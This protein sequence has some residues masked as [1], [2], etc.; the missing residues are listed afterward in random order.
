MSKR[1]G[2]WQR[3]RDR[4]QINIKHKIHI[5]MDTYNVSIYN[6]IQNEY[7]KYEMAN[8]IIAQYLIALHVLFECLLAFYR[9]INYPFFR[10]F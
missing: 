1:V 8:Y 9:L 10:K 3:K 7:N 5:F 2:E 6:I 4:R